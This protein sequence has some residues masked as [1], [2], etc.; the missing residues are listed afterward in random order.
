MFISLLSL[1]LVCLWFVCW[2]CLLGF[3]V[4]FALLFVWFCGLLVILFVVGL[5][6]LIAFVH[7]YL[8]RD[9]VFVMIVVYG[10]LVWWLFV[11]FVYLGVC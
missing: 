7:L 11:L 9:V 3:I 8:L 5:V 1:V 10:L 4:M 2:F 6:L